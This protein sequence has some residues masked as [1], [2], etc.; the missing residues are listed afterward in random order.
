MRLGDFRT[1]TAHLPDDYVIAT[2]DDGDCASFNPL[3]EGKIMPPVFV[4][5][6]PGIVLLR[7]DG[8]SWAEEVDFGDRFDAWLE[9][10]NSE[11]FNSST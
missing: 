1:K 10:G 7:F 3:T 9:N 11:S 5:G 2:D 6:H 4:L 8:Q